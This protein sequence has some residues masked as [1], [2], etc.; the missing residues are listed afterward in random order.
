MGIEEASVKETKKS[1][2]TDRRRKKEAQWILF[3]F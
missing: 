1:A 2:D 3:L